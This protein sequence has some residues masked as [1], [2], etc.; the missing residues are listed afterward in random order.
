MEETK[1]YVGSE[2]HEKEVVRLH[3]LI[4]DRLMTL[5]TAR[6]RLILKH[7]GLPPL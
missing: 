3:R 7:A 1:M 5:A 6:V 4:N 2:Q